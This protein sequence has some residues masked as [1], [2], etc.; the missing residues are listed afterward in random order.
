MTLR[1]LALIVLLFVSGCTSYTPE[2]EARD[3]K[4]LKQLQQERYRYEEQ[5]KKNQE[6]IDRYEAI[7]RALI[8]EGIK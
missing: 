8:R 3:R 5:Q 1:L 2:Q 6:A 7:Q 4:E